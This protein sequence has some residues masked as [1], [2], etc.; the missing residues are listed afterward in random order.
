LLRN[1]VASKKQKQPLVRLF[2]FCLNLFCGRIG[3][4]NRVSNNNKILKI[5]KTKKQ[6][7]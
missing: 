2:L 4:S 7:N 5:W 1:H 6:E 3:V